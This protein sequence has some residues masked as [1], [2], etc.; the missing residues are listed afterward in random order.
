MAVRVYGKSLVSYDIWV[1]LTEYS[2]TNRVT[3]SIPSDKCYECTTAGTSGDSEPSWNSI[4]E[5]TTQDGTVVWTCKNTPS[6]PNPL[7][8]IID[9][10]GKGG[11]ALM[12]LWVKSDVECEFLVYG[13]YNGADG[14]WRLTEDIAI[15]T[16]Q[17][18]YEKH[19]GYF[20]AYPFAKV[21]VSGAG[22]HEIEIIAG[23]M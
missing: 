2:L 14:T 13:S 7:T 10:S 4:P 17:G 6:G 9:A 15:P 1:A 19:E 11:L 8:V 18:K 22:N 20:N 23:E 21:S 16:K 3:A 12:E 5:Q